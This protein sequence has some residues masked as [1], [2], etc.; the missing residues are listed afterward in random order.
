MTERRQLKGE[1]AEPAK[2]SQML[3]D[4][5]A[6][7]EANLLFLEPRL[8]HPGR[9]TRISRDLR[10]RTK[11]KQTGIDPLV[12]H[13]A[14]TLLRRAPQFFRLCVFWKGKEKSDRPT[15]RWEICASAAYMSVRDK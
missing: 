7:S 1:S 13:L 9:K 15:S 5:R 11:G 4:S 8:F 3:K 10:Q 2:S 6:K 12:C 14:H